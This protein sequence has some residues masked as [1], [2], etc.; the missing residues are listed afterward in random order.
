[1]HHLGTF[2]SAGST[3]SEVARPG[4]TLPFAV[5]S[6]ISFN[7]PLSGTSA[8]TWANRRASAVFEPGGFVRGEEALS[9]KR[10]GPFERRGGLVRPHALKIG[11]APRRPAL[12]A[13]GG[14]IQENQNDEEEDMAHEALSRDYE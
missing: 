11:I 3:I 6:Q 1:V 9:G 5:S 12:G 8:A 13:G 7:S 10:I 4:G 2:P 14:S